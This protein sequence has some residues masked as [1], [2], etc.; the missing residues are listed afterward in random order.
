V[1]AEVLRLLRAADQGNER[2]RQGLG[3]ALEMTNA[4]LSMLAGGETLGIPLAS[5]FYDIRL[6]G[7]GGESLLETFGVSIEGTFGLSYTE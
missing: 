4:S 2:L 5:G 6:V 1:L 3:V 7:C